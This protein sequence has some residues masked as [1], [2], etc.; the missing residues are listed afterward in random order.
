MSELRVVQCGP[1][2]CLQ[3]AGRFGFQRFG[4]SP[5]GA[6]DPDALLLANLLVGNPED[7]AAI[8]FCMLGGTF[9][10][11][12]GS[13]MLALCGGDATLV[14]GARPI[15]PL[16]STRAEDGET[17]IVRPGREGVYSYL[18]VA[19]GFDIIP[20]LGSLSLHRRA[21]LGGAPLQGGDVLALAGEAESLGAMRLPKAEPISERPIRVML[22]PQDDFFTADAIATLLSA[23][24]TVSPQADRM[25]VRLTGPRLEHAKGFNIVSDGIVTGHIQVP[26]DGQPIVLLRDRQTTGGYPKIAT[27]ITADLARFAQMRPGSQLRFQAVSREEAIAA[28]RMAHAL[29]RS[30]A[31][32]IMTA[33]RPISTALLLGTNLISGVT[34]GSAAESTSRDD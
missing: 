18:A 30:L 25:G 26:G 2:T 16:T 12:G 4:V 6:M 17:V 22:G 31:G 32:Q 21:G 5:A 20:E 19:G 24:F 13:A 14:V 29:R 33:D 27:I 8:E 1:G 28:A 15:S 7:R 11:S 23:T 34:G 10:V 3:D 9:S